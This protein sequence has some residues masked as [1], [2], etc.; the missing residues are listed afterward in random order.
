V[1]RLNA[2]PTLSGTSDGIMAEKN[3]DNDNMAEKNDEQSILFCFILFYF[4][5]FITT[6][7]LHYK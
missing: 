3:D 5:S 1:L 7:R 2:F 6:L 4:R